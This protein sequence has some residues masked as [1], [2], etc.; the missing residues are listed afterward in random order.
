[1]PGAVTI[2]NAALITA[3]LIGFGYLH[4]LLQLQPLHGDDP[5]GLRAALETVIRAAASA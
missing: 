1:M 5:E 4:L 3:F 2:R